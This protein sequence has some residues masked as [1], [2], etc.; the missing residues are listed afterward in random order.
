MMFSRKIIVGH[1]L[2]LIIAASC[3]ALSAWQFA[4]L[5][6]REHLNKKV[7]SRE[8][9]TPQPL[10]EV[11][12][13]KSI[14]S[15]EYRNV[16]LTG[17]YLT[18]GQIFIS[19]R[20]DNEDAGYNV[21]TPF[22]LDND[23]VVYV[24]RGWIPQTLGDAFRDGD[25]SADAV[26]PVQGYKHERTVVGLVRKNEPKPFLGNNNQ[27]GSDGIGNRIAVQLFRDY[28]H[29]S[30]KNLYMFW[31]QETSEHVDGKTIKQE[32]ND[33]PIKYPTLLEKPSLSTG[34]HLSYAIQWIFFGFLAIITWGVICFQS[35]KKAKKAKA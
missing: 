33:A 10:N 11:A 19:G 6:Q 34:P 30:T 26:E 1:F 23:K 18:K 21:L 8:T 4:R 5:H 2:V 14:S 32:R 16:A 28:S 15:I 24:N 3:F 25:A 29:F 7:E 9:F 27:V 13:N 17:H 22:Q 35:Q 31:I 20:S 12:T